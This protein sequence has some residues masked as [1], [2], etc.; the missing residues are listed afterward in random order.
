MSLTPLPRVFL[1][2]NASLTPSRLDSRVRSRSLYEI[3]SPVR[4]Y[5]QTILSPT[6]LT[7]KYHRRHPGSWIR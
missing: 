5:P 2:Y 1:C 6:I 4:G 3:V 7:P